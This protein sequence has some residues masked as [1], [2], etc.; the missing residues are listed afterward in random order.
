MISAPWRSAAIRALSSL[1]PTA[2]RKVSI[3]LG[4]RM[5]RKPVAVLLYWFAFQVA[6]L[7]IQKYGTVN[8]LPRSCS[9]GTSV[10]KSCVMLAKSVDTSC[11]LTP[12]RFQYPATASATLPS[13]G[14]PANGKVYN[15]ISKPLVNPACW[16]NCCAC[17]GSYGMAGR[18]NGAASLGHR[19]GT[20]P[21]AFAA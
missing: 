14:T 6:T 9:D 19:F 1:A 20:L 13:Q 15:L 3:S 21:S 17:E 8:A 12:I 2:V 4:S 7:A 11:V 16:I 5:F 18:V 10:L